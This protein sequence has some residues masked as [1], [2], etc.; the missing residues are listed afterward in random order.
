MTSERSSHWC[1]S[2]LI[3][4]YNKNIPWSMAHVWLIPFNRWNE[5]SWAVHCSVEQY[6]LKSLASVADQARDGWQWFMIMFCAHFK[7]HQDIRFRLIW[8]HGP[9]KHC[10]SHTLSW[11]ETRKNI[12]TSWSF[13]L[14]LGDAGWCW[15][16]LVVLGDHCHWCAGEGGRAG[17]VW[18][19]Y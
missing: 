13:I 15:V 10:I 3:I 1:S 11:A 4:L 9:A 6:P 8:T 18:L 16:M 19:E 2:S 17:R 5:Q 12:W 14:M 7:H